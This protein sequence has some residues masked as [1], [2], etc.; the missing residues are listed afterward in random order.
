MKRRVFLQAA[1]GGMAG[2]WAASPVPSASAWNERRCGVL[3]PFPGAVLSHRHGV[4]TADRLTIHVTGGAPAEDRVSVNGVP[5]KRQGREFDAEVPLTDHET[6]LLAVA[7]GRS[8]SQRTKCRHRQRTVPA[9]PAIVSRSTEL[10]SFFL[11]RHA[12]KSH[13][14]CEDPSMFVLRFF[15]ICSRY[16]W[17]NC[18]GLRT[19]LLRQAEE[20]RFVADSVSDIPSSPRYRAWRGQRALG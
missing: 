16:A 1:A 3:D 7:E 2:L 12:G 10:S 9:S 19:S 18:M 11:R 5:A 8:G 4:Q 13:H 17:E 14:G 6:D 20:D 15:V